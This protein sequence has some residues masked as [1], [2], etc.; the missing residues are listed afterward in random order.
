MVTGSVAAASSTRSTGSRFFLASCPAY[1]CT[2]AR[3]AAVVKTSSTCGWP[4]TRRAR[5]PIKAA[6]K[7]LASAASFTARFSPQFEIG[8]DFFFRS[9]AGLEPPADFGAQ[10]FKEL[11]FQIDGESAFGRGEKDACHSTP[12]CDENR[13]PGPEQP[14]GFVAKFTDGADS[15]VVT[16]VTII[17]QPKNRICYDNVK[18]I[19]REPCL[20]DSWPSSLCSARRPGWR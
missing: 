2:S 10:F 9:S 7:T 14:R 13:L 20:R 11:A 1:S 8:L 3:V 15:H 19:L 18:W 4:R 6:S 5:P 16:L 12:A 17:I